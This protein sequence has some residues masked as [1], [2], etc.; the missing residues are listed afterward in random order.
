MTIP[1]P[2]L[3]LLI[4]EVGGAAA[5]K[6]WNVISGKDNADE[7]AQATVFVSK[8]ASALESLKKAFGEEKINS[9]IRQAEDTAKD[10]F[11]YEAG[12]KQYIKFKIEDDSIKNKIEI[13]RM[14]INENLDRIV[15]AY[16]KNMPT[17]LNEFRGVY[18]E[19]KK[20]Y[21]ELLGNGEED[22][23]SF[24]EIEVI[25]NKKA[26]QNK[27]LIFSI[28]R[29]AVGTLG[30]GFMFRAYQW[31]TGYGLSVGGKVSRTIYGIPYGKIFALAGI[32]IVIIVLALRLQYNEKEIMSQC[33]S[34]AYKLLEAKMVC[35]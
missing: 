13:L 25:L 30:A 3:K 33:I 10:S 21:I 35:I 23:E 6:I 29:A 16:N 28:M 1:I 24:H 31:L 12:R 18:A 15:K 26:I 8:G 2:L 20:R 14:E 7:L 34:R 27:N 17:I 4:V 9:L 5:S 32:G 19:W 22:Q 11:C